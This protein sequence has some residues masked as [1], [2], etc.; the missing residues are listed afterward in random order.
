MRAAA[1]RQDLQRHSGMV[2]HL[3]QPAKLVPHDSRAAH[4]PA[5]RPLVHDGPQTGRVRAHEHLLPGEP[6]R[7]APDDVVLRQGVAQLDERPG[8]TLRLEQARNELELVV[9]DERGR[10][11]Q[12]EVRL[13]PVRQDVGVALPPARR[14]RVPGQLEQGL[15]L[16]ARRHPVQGQQIGDVALFESDSSKLHAADLGMRTADGGRR[17]FGRHARVFAEPPQVAA[18]NEALHRRPAGALSMQSLRNLPGGVLRLSLQSGVLRRD[19]RHSSFG[20][21]HS[22]SWAWAWVSLP[23]DDA[24]AEED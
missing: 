17:L 18:K 5:Q 9:P 19:H 24:I 8:V 13:D 7:D 3:D 21:A 15:P 11:L 20:L 22:S 14:V 1:E 23:C 6:R 4:W 12:S 10:R 2:A 16:L